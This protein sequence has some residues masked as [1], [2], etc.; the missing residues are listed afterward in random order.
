[1]KSLTK[2]F[3]DYLKKRNQESLHLEVEEVKR[4]KIISLVFFLFIYFI[5]HIILS[6]D[7]NKLYLLFTIPFL[8]LIYDK[9]ILYFSYRKNK[10][11]L[12]GEKYEKNKIYNNNNRDV[13][14]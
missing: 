8:G 6:L 12:K 3:K 14:S 1:L 10:K 7:L 9:F 4:M 2:I 11:E 13:I 5:T